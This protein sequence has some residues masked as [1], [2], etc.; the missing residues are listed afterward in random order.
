MNFTSSLLIDMISPSTA[1]P[2]FDSFIIY[3][4]HWYPE[5]APW[6]FYN[7]QIERAGVVRD[8]QR[9]N[10]GQEVGNYKMVEKS[11]NVFSCFQ[12][13]KSCEA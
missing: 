2:G 7:Q 5:R 3:K 6:S 11:C 12:R 13:G 10:M 8:A 1:I 4:A 9:E